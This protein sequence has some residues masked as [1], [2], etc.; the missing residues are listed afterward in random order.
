MAS[1]VPVLGTL[2]DLLAKVGLDWLKTRE[3][4][5]T[6]AVWIRE[7]LVHNATT[8]RGALLDGWE[9]EELSRNRF[10]NLGISFVRQ[11]GETAQ[12]WR[13]LE[14]VYQFVTP[15][16][17]RRLGNGV[18]AKAEAEKFNALA[19]QINRESPDSVGARRELYLKWPELMKEAGASAISFEEAWSA[20]SAAM[21]GGTAALISLAVGERN[22]LADN[23]LRENESFERWHQQYPAGFAVTVADF[24]YELR[25]DDRKRVLFTFEPGPVTVLSAV[26]LAA[27]LPPGWI[28]A[29][30]VAQA[31]QR[32]AA[33]QLGYH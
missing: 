25:I 6:A 27:F 9:G 4:R 10:D 28:P 7:E 29:R 5:R 22:E 3:G 21:T 30:V 2:A 24:I 31:V 20:F 23:P 17:N 32:R 18:R 13:N 8:L 14:D 33:W 12:L 19:V 16:V 11:R 26:E 1:P 15:G